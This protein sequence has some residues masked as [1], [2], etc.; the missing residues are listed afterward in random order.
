MAT[1]ATSHGCTASAT[2]TVGSAELSNENPMP[3]LHLTVIEVLT[4]RTLIEIRS[5]FA[6]PTDT[7]VVWVVY[8]ALESSGTYHQVFELAGTVTGGAATF[9]PS[10]ELSLP[11]QVAHY[12]AL[13]VLV[14]GPH[15]EYQSVSAAKPLSFAAVV[16][17]S[18]ANM[19]STVEELWIEVR[20]DG[21]SYQT[22]LTEY[23]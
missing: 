3:T 20:A 17:S 7:D 4:P 16:G 15:T 1:S 10:G 22:V 19:S 11:L 18:R 21:I 13:G 2:D 8:E 6:V 12:Y 23:L 14:T 9:H 5:Y